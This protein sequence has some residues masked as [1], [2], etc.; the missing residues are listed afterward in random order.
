MANVAQGPAGLAVYFLTKNDKLKALALPS[1]FSAFIGIT[2]PVIYGVNLRLGKPFIGG[3]IGGPIGGGYVVL[4]QVAA[5]A[6]GLTGIPMIAIVTPL[7]AT[8][9][10]NYL[11]GFAIAVVT[12][13]VS[14]DVLM[15]LD[16]GKQKETD[17]AA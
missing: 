14:T 8:N 2:E 17:I 11:V 1:A 15:R 9:L 4:T 7:G 3:A 10:I 5:N 6:Y 12:A 16:A 13:F